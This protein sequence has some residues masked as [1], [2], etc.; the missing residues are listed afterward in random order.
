[1]W[2]QNLSLKR[3]ESGDHISPGRNSMLIQLVDPDMEF[4]TPKHKFKDIRQ[5]KFLDLE[6]TD[7]WGDDQK[8]TDDQAKEITDALQY[9]LDNN[10]NVITHCIMGL[11]RSGAV[12][13][14]GVMMGFDDKKFLRI[15]N[16]LVK[17]KMMKALGWAYDN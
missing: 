11:C 9:A 8:I 12:C 2:I 6:D 15:P 10:M 17:Q 7:E 14:I 5:F 13:E 16:L 4:P 1:M 3:I